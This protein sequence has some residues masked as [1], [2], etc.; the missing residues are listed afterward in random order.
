MNQRADAE[1]YLSRV[2]RDINSSQEEEYSNYNAYKPVWSNPSG[3]EVLRKI[4]RGKYS[5]VFEGWKC[6][7]GEPDKKVCIKI[8]KPV[9][10]K[11][12]RREIMILKRLNAESKEN[13]PGSKY[14]IRLLDCT[15]DPHSKIKCLIF[16]YVDACDF[17]TLYP[18]LSDEDVRYYMFQLLL[19]LDYCHSQGVI[20]RDV[21]PHNVMINHKLGKLRLIDWGLAEFYHPG[22][23]YNVRVASR[24]YKGPE[25]LLNH[26]Y[27]DY[28][29]DIWSFGCMLA[30]MVFIRHP[31]FHGKSNEDQLVKI[32]RV[33]GTAGLRTY[34]NKY[35]LRL[36]SAYEPVKA[37][38]DPKRAYPQ[39]DLEV[40]RDSKNKKFA[41]DDAID[42]L[43]Q[44]LR[45]DHQARP[46]C[47]EAMS[48]KYF[49]KTRED[50]KKG[51]PPVRKQDIPCLFHPHGHAVEKK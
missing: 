45:Y 12:I 39:R 25:L 8:L 49:N 10:K 47:K 2:Y 23:E 14:V 31:F 6:R 43:N 41:K 11:K 33:L 46:T 20:H 26:R 17:K 5:D 50:Y 21:K 36:S 40:F 51:Q 1:L 28:S 13:H 3:Y 42:L 34:M 4:G 16:E 35:N 19:A 24:Y 30:G 38:F 48:H 27:Y 22:K 9:K 7:K 44:C 15:M 18:S 32:L 37:E 29:L